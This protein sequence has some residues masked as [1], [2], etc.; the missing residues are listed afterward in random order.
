MY[1]LKIGRSWLSVGL[2]AWNFT[3][4]Y[5]LQSRKFHIASYI[6]FVIAVDLKAKHTN[7]VAY[8]LQ[9]RTTGSELFNFTYPYGLPEKSSKIEMSINHTKSSG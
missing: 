6:F 3:L 7:S 2:L 9:L 4:S 5:L 1:W 8:P